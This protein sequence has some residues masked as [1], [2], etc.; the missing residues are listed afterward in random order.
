MGITLLV[1]MT[2]YYM[3]WEVVNGIPVPVFDNLIK[4]T[5]D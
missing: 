3:T 1:S 2:G 5:G 4:E